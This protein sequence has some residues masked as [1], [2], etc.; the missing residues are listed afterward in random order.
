MIDTDHGAIDADVLA[1]LQQSFA[2][3]ELLTAIEAI[4][5]SEGRQKWLRACLV[6]LHA[7]AN[8]LINGAP[9][10]VTGEEAIW[11]LAEEIGDELDA[12]TANLAH[13]SKLVDRL[14]QLRPNG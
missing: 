6:R 4:E 9:Q 5:A 14:G 10:A 2:T 11:Q 3:S 8:H 13:V 1:E 7:M 12:R